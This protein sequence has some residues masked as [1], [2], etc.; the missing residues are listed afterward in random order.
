LDKISST[1]YIVSANG[2]QWSALCPGSPPI[3]YLTTGPITNIDNNFN[4]I[5][6]T[7]GTGTIYKVRY[8][9]YGIISVGSAG[10]SFGSYTGTS[11]QG[12]DIYVQTDGKV[13]IAGSQAVQRFN[14]DT[15]RDTT[16]TNSLTYG[17]ADAI[18]LQSTGKII[19]VGGGKI[20]RLNTNG[21][22]DGTFKVGTLSN[23]NVR[24]SDVIVDGSDRI[25]V[26]S[27]S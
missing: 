17:G 7:G 24:S 3:C 18:S 14:S 23:A 21:T 2:T 1:Q 26:V 8:T 27:P 6:S 9:I 20:R 12:R 4:Y 13:L 25:Y 10:S 19:V 22:D 15:T 11:A 5:S 16:F